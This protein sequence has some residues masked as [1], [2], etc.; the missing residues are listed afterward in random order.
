MLALAGFGAWSLAWSRVATNGAA[1]VVMLLLTKDRYRPG[2]N[3]VQAKTLLAFGL[4]LAGA[5]LLVFGVL[6][7]DYIVVGSVLGPVALAF[8]LM[9]FNLSSWPVG[10]FS[11]PVRSVSLPAFSRVRDDPERFSA[12]FARA[13]GLL[14]LFAL[15]ACVLLAAL[16]APL[17]RFAYGERWGAAIAPLAI[18]MVLGA[19][20][21][22]SELAYD[23][24][25]SDGRSRAVLMIH[26]G[27]LVALI[28]ALAI[29][30]HLDGIRGVAVGHIVV[31]VLLVVPAY[32]NVL[33]PYGLRARVLLAPLARPVLGAALM[34]VPALG[35]QWLLD[36]DIWQLMVGG[37]LGL[38]VYIAVVFPLR[39][40]ALR[41]LRRRESA[42]VAV[43]GV[44]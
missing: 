34:T 30:A 16:G 24:L 29:G 36:G 26:L 41:M 9:A 18:L 11:A 3:R 8:Y 1:A 10:A 19:I 43:G 32:L 13:L 21:V 40:D 35:V 15:P 27:W 20:R 31:V 38:A 22:A 42:A 39:H 5:S 4:P 12:T 37:V 44:A 23:F 25:A 7:V 33:R 2:F 6:N 14:A 17:I 28:P